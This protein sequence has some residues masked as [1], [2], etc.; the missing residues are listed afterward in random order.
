MKIHIS[1][2]TKA[3]LDTFNKFEIIERGLIDIKVK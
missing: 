1:E 3:I 2:S